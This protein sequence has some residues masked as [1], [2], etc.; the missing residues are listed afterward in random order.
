MSLRQTPKDSATPTQAWQAMCSYPAGAPLVHVERG[1]TAPYPMETSGT[2]LLARR[3][4]I[5]QRGATKTVP[6]DLSSVDSRWKAALKRHFGDGL[7]ADGI[8]YRCWHNVKGLV[9]E[10]DHYAW[11]EFQE[12]YGDNCMMVSTRALQE[13]GFVMGHGQRW[14]F[15]TYHYNDY[16]GPWDWNV[17]WVVQ[18]WI[19]ALEKDQRDRVRKDEQWPEPTKAQWDLLARF[20]SGEWNL[21]GGEKAWK[22][23]SAESR[24]AFEALVEA[25]FESA[26]WWVLR[27]I[28]EYGAP[29]ELLEFTSNPD[30]SRWDEVWIRKMLG[31][32]LA[33]QQ[34][35][36][37]VY[38]LPEGVKPGS[39]LAQRIAWVY[40]KR[41]EFF[42]KKW[43]GW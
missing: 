18:M 39:E 17:D 7:L 27:Y 20:A 8:G 34:N 40:F 19:W 21:E 23:L 25:A 30:T 1:R 2:S 4:Q 16:T 10:E 36:S 41:F 9:L 32:I 24:A 15:E 28:R 42:K 11:D 3:Q 37:V 31:C 33:L 6:N 26:P 13:A 12:Y 29:P 22:D 5:M 43:G 35:G 14:T 38:A